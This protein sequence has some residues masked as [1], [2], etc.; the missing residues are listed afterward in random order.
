MFIGFR[1]HKYC[2]HHVPKELGRK[3]GARINLTWRWIVQ[4]CDCPCTDPEANLSVARKRSN[5][6]VQAAETLREAERPVRRRLADA[7]S[8]KMAE[9]RPP[10]EKKAR[11]RCGTSGKVPS[12]LRCTQINLQTCKTPKKRPRKHGQSTSVSHR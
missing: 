6:D 10:K 8:A 2:K 5:R 4:H 1:A 11:L 9:P 12:V 7:P 3:V